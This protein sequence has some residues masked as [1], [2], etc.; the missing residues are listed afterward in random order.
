MTLSCPKRYQIIQK[1]NC[2]SKWSYFKWK[3]NKISFQKHE[4]LEPLKAR[5]I[6]IRQTDI[7]FQ[8]NRDFL[9]EGDYFAQSLDLVLKT[10]CSY[11]YGSSLR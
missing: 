1:N 8:R 5:I 9:T 3:L 6:R 7:W 2:W 11:L 4:T 10:S